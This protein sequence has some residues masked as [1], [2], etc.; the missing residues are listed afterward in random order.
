M[1]P[2]GLEDASLGLRELEIVTVDRPAVDLD[3]ALVDHPAPVAGGV[4]QLLGQECR[5]VDLGLRHAHPGDV[6]GR[7][8]L[9]HDAREVLLSAPRALVSVPARDD[10]AR[11]LE[12][13]LHR[14]VGMLSA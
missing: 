14:V 10:A 3:A 11:E 7:L 2:P 1:A 6:R 8:V 12:L 5:Q 9:T 4:A 13:P